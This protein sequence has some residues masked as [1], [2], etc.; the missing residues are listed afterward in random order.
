MAERWKTRNSQIL[1]DNPW[2]KVRRDAVQ[3]P[4]G[5][6][7]DDFYA[8][9]IR[10]ASAIVALDAGGNL[11]LKREYRYCHDREL[12]EI[13][14]GMH[15]DEAGMAYDAWCLGNF[16]T[17]RFLNK[18]PVYLINYGSGQSA[19]Y[20]YLTMVFLKFGGVNLWMIR[21]P[22]ISSCTKAFRLEDFFRNTCQRGCAFSSI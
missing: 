8:I 7:I 2:V 12:T 14:A 18:W 4:N 15:V 9:T 10:D 22:D 3:L 19:M 17:D 16:G 1:L 20:A 11:I 6:R 5:A 13:P 21:M